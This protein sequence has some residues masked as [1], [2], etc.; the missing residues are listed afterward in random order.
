MQ[1]DHPCKGR[2]QSQID[3]FEAIAI[4]EHP[5]CSKKTLDALLKDNLI[6][7]IGNQE[8]GRDAFGAITVPVY[9]VPIHHH[10]QWCQWASEQF[11]D[12]EV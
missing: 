8:L 11:D 2:S 6:V 4:N 12:E 5:N 7:V 9:E 3:A 1:T 10:M